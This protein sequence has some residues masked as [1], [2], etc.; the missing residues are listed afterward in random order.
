MFR[1]IVNAAF[2]IKTDKA[3]EP[4]SKQSKND[5]R[6]ALIRSKLAQTLLEQRLKEADKRLVQFE[7]HATPDQKAYDLAVRSLQDRGYSLDGDPSTDALVG[8]LVHLLNAEEEKFREYKSLVERLRIERKAFDEWRLGVR[9]AA[10]L[11]SA[12]GMPYSVR[13]LR[14]VAMSDPEWRS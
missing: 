11:V 9:K 3:D 2:G 12:H 5:L 8:T 10:E 13:A 1:K 6:I 14:E 7:A 4:L